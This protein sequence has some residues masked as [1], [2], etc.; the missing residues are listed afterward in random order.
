MPLANL[1]NV[2]T[3]EKAAE[4]RPAAFSVVRLT[5]NYAMFSGGVNDP[6]LI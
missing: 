3:T 4:R 2:L 5:K 1:A 6:L